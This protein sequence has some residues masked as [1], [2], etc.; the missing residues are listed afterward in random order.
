MKRVIARKGVV[1]G[2]FCPLTNAH[3]HMIEFARNYVDEL[4][5]VVDEHAADAVNAEGRVAW[6]KELFP[7]VSIRRVKS[8]EWHKSDVD[9]YGRQLLSGLRRILPKTGTGIEGFLFC[10]EG[11]GK[12]LAEKLGA[13]YIPCNPSLIGH[14]TTEKE[15]RSNPL[16]HWDSLP[17]IVRPHF[18]RRVCVFGP[19]ST[20]KSTLAKQ[21]AK[22]F[23]TAYVPEYAQTYIATNGKDIDDDDMLAIAR[24]QCALEDAVARDA[25]RVLF[26]DSDL[27]TSILWSGRLIGTVPEWLRLEADKRH[28]DLYLLTHYDVP[29][30]DDAHRYIPKES[31]AFFDRCVL[32]LDGR[33]RPYAQ[34]KGGWDERFQLAVAAVEKML[35]G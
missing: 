35:K 22:H 30:V 32:E 13:T 28:Y 33:K 6:L 34:I 3:V 9:D 29:W 16:K 15:I 10:L 20:G 19:E 26:C 17:R 23:G 31:P 14:S 12:L 25:N 4:I 8:V 18:V 5:I 7:G 27:V 1:L 2:D 11:R 21:L 24:G